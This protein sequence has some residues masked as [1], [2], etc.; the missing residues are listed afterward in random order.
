[1]TTEKSK[2][3][4]KGR[5][6]EESTHACRIVITCDQP[7]SDGKMHVEMSYEGDP[8]LASYVL[9]RAQGFIEHDDEEG[10]PGG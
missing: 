6:K 1:M 4:L 7:K 3:S 9:E 10:F 5:L 2:A 8:I